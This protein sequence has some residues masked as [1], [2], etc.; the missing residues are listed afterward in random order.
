MRLR[1]E[2]LGVLR[3]HPGQ[4]GGKRAV[5]VDRDVAQAVLVRHLVQE[6]EQDLG[7]AESERR[8]QHRA[9]P[10]KGLLQHG[11]E[12]SLEVGDGLMP[13]VAVGALHDQQ[14][15]VA[16]LLGEDEG[17]VVEDRFAEA[18]DVPR[19]CH[20]DG[21]PVLARGDHADGRPQDVP[22]VVEGAGHPV[23]DGDRV[24]VGVAVEIGE[25]LPGVGHRV[26]GCDGLEAQLGDQVVDGAHVELVAAL[27]EEL[28]DLSQVRSVVVAARAGEA[29]LGERR[30]HGLVVQVVRVRLLDAARIRKQVLARRGRGA[31]ADDAAGET[32]LGHHR[33]PAGVVEVGMGEHDIGEQAGVEGQNPVFLG[34]LPAPTLKEPAVQQHAVAVRGDEV[35]GP[36][37]FARRAVKS[38]LHGVFPSGIVHRRMP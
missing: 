38:D 1:V 25:R 18:A 33:D 17:G 8:D 34:G 6:V 15:D 26:E 28:L 14:V 2:H 30:T 16:L 9:P 3:E 12:L 35:H 10:L 36:R 21:A 5:H 23:A 22:G 32:V 29:L 27:L 37:D 19:E 20:P 4:V 7:P 31:G 13:A 24:A 11:L